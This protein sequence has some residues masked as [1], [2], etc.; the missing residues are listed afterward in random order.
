MQPRAVE[1]II[2]VSHFFKLF[3]LTILILSRFAFLTFLLLFERFITPVAILP[4]IPG[5]LS[6]DYLPLP[7]IFPHIDSLPAS[8][9]TPRTSRLDRFF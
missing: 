4:L 7:Q 9:L 8:G 3:N 5:R 2:S 6:G 1:V